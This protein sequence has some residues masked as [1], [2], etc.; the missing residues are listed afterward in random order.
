VPRDSLHR[1]GE[2]LA[3]HTGGRVDAAAYDRDAPALVRAKLF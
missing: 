1:M 2:I 3:A